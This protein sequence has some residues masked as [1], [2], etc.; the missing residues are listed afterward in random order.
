MSERAT[1]FGLDRDDE[2]LKR[3][4]SRL[5][6]FRDRVRLLLGNF[7]DLSRLVEEA[8]IGEADGIL[9]DLGVS[10]LHLTK[11]ER[12]FMFS[13]SGPLSMR[14]GPDADVDVETVI[15]EASE[16]ELA[17]I[18]REYGEESAYKKLARAIVS[19]RIRHR[20]RTTGDLA[21]VVRR[22][23]RPPY[24]IKSMARV[25][26]AFRIYVNREIDNLR[27]FLPQALECLRI[28]GRLAVISY[29]SLEDREVK[30]F[31]RTEAASCIC[32]PDFPVCRCGHVARLRPLGK[33]ITPDADEISGN[34]SARSAR[35]R[36][37]EKIA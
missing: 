3:A 32:P 33:L 26:Q 20:L 9:A 34:P 22:V 19:R 24:V 7:R 21:D 23:V 15:N 35:M 30:D 27:Q 16:E 29:H 2:A 12:G 13:E 31:Y 11:P 4:E 10:H 8:G 36:L 25:F 1:L 5:A 28:G 6:P 14:M 17:Q 37:A 18:I